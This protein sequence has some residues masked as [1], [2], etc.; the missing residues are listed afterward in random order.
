M[1]YPQLIFE[2]DGVARPA[3]NSGEL[4]GLW[5]PRLRW[6]KLAKI[7]RAW[8]SVRLAANFSI[9]TSPI[10]LGKRTP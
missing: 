9:I 3:A 10:G 4:A 6:A 1:A 5:R 8:A 2:A 7:L